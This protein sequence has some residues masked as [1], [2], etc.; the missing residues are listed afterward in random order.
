MHP[1]TVSELLNVWERGAGERPFERA[2]EI[3]SAAAPETPA[4]ALAQV[5]IGRRD[6]RLLR[7][8]E[9]AF[10]SELPIMAACPRC[11]HPLETTLTV[12]DLCV[13][14][15]E[16]GDPEISLT[17][18]QYKVRCHVPNSEDLAACVGSDTAASRR[19]LLRRC[20]IEACWGDQVV[21]GEELPEPVIETVVRRIAAADQA[22]IRIDLTCPDCGHRWDEVFDIVSFFWTE[23]DAW[24][25]RLLREVHVL[26]SAY[27]WNEREILALS[28][29]RR[30]IYLA[31]AEQ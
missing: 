17:I 3:L 4:A 19:A 6:A 12:G 2:L 23:I 31:M 7:L 16:A 25:R 5:S 22:E 20:V 26:A 11:H 30:Q 10:G 1:L 29:I 8:R 28:P 18:G 13:P 21:P 24:A 27:G 15:E 9:W 14:T